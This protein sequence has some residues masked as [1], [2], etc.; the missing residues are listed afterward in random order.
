MNDQSPARSKARNILSKLAAAAYLVFAL[1]VGLF[2]VT[3]GLSYYYADQAKA[4]DSSAV[5]N[6]LKFDVRNP[7]IYK[8]E[9]SKLLASE[10]YPE[11][12]AALQKA[13]ELR[14]RDYLLH[15]RL[16]YAL[17]R[18][19]DAEGARQSYLRALA[20]APDY[21]QSNRYL[22]RLL[23]KLGETDQAFEYLGRAAALDSTLYGE[24]LHLARVNLPKADAS[25]N[26][27]ADLI[28]QKLKI[29]SFEGRKR[30]AQ[31]F[32]RH[33]MLNEA[34]KNF[35]FAGPLSGD[36]KRRFINALVRYG[37]FRM[38]RD[39]WLTVPENKRLTDE[40]AD[41]FIIDGG[42]EKTEASDESAVSWQ[43]ENRLRY[44]KAAIDERVRRSGSR[45]LYISFK[46]P[47][48]FKTNFISQIVPVESGRS[49]ALEAAV[50]NSEIVSG[51]SLE[52]VV[53]DPA[54]NEIIGKTGSFVMKE[55]DWKIY[56]ASFRAGDSAAVMIALRRAE[57]RANPCP[58]FAE[59]WLDDIA[60][61]ASVR[62]D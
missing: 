46:G 36:E 58:I 40:S 43:I 6:A 1:A 29:E 23:L 8:I 32:I 44:V 52:L 27:S 9:G 28:E 20:L 45:S 7:E 48:E 62:T 12:A 61:T 33:A 19:G 24:V 39:L 26:A 38:A 21:A 53:I 60:L 37:H 56:R 34:T 10:N 17:Y 14:D 35:L 18:S 49:Y 25:E 3:K 30:A 11:A 47:A 4:G 51:G 55:S 42:F 59:I 16:G 2:S 15:L 31:Y 54:T 22:G 5:S 41:T 57:C 13:V 50:K